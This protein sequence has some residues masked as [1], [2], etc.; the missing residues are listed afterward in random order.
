MPIRPSTVDPLDELGEIQRLGVDALRDALNDYAQCVVTAMAQGPRDTKREKACLEELSRRFASLGAHADV[1]GRTRALREVKADPVPDPATFAEIKH[2]REKVAPGTE[3]TV[4]A[5]TFIQGASDTS[6]GDVP[7]VVPISSILIHGSLEPAKLE[8][9]E[10]W[11][12]LNDPIKMPSAGLDEGNRLTLTNGRHRIE[13]LRRRGATVI[14]VMM[15][16]ADANLYEAQVSANIPAGRQPSKREAEALE[17]VLTS[18]RVGERRLIGKTTVSRIGRTQWSFSPGNVPAS[19]THDRRT[20]VSLLAQV[21]LQASLP[22]PQVLP[23]KAETPLAR[24][25]PGIMDEPF[26]AAVE[27]LAR[28][29]PELALSPD[30]MKDVYAQGGFALVRATDEAITAKVQDMIIK[31]LAE[32]GD[33]LDTIEIMKRLDES[34]TGPY[35]ET[36]V[37]NATNRA[38]AAGRQQ[39]ANDL[40]SVVGLEFSTSG[41][42]DVRH[43][44]AAA[45][46]IIAS[47][48]DPVWDYLSPPLGHR[49]RCVLQLV[50]RTR[51]E[52]EGLLGPDGKLPRAK[53]PS[54][55]KPDP[56]GT[57]GRRADS[58]YKG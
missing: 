4:G 37:R 42:L 43:N 1:L 57:W 58:L 30:A 36:V 34:F 55:A 52:R 48:D 23:A 16:K 31:E 27:A 54:D 20:A 2:P 26:G 5:W 3:V 28:Q 24:D 17:G 53:V 47:V 10:A 45:D 56:G 9:F 8:R 6:L 46:G 21:Y 14:P 13:I 39:Q 51:A 19:Q 25:L 18:L 11:L 41:D 44:H 7:V 35:L 15:P 38:Y 29:S 12:K 22:Y 40:P 50:T 49:C 32:G 33:R